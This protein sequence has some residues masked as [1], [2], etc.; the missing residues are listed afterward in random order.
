VPIFL[1]SG[2]LKLLELSGPVQARK[3]TALLSLLLL[4]LLLLLLYHLKSRLLA[5]GWK[6]GVRIPVRAKGFLVSKLT[7]VYEMAIQ[8]PIQLIL[9]FSRG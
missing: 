4:L 2:S 5:T 8:P 9:F 3:G 7:K 1:K 6:G